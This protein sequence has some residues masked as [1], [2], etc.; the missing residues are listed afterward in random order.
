[1]S[2]VL[3]VRLVH[4]ESRPCVNAFFSERRVHGNLW[5]RMLRALIY[6]TGH[7][8]LTLDCSLIQVPKVP[9]SLPCPLALS[10]APC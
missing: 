2:G 3:S 5:S 1:M 7:R 8:H 4:V 9:S 6:S 10:A